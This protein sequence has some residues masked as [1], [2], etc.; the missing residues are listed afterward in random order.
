MSYCV[1]C[2]VELAPSEEKCPLCKTPVL[3][4]NQAW[5]EPG[6]R[7]Y[8]ERLEVVPPH[9]DRQYGA[10]L[11]SLFLMIPMLAVLI[12]DMVINL[13]MTWVHVCIGRGRVRLLLGAA[14][15][16][17]D[18][19]RPYFYI[20]VDIA[21]AALYLLL[22]AFLT[23]GD[24][25][26]ALALPLTLIWG[27]AAML[28]VYIGRRASMAPLD[29]ASLVVLVGAAALAGLEVV[30]D[31]WVL[32]SVRLEW[33]LYALA[34][35]AASARCSGSL[36]ESQAQGEHHE[37]T[38]PVTKSQGVESSPGAFR[39]E[40]GSLPAIGG[41]IKCSPGIPQSLCK[42]VVYYCRNKSDRK[43]L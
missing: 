19:E 36:N 1:H 35:L 13:R 28:S 14:P 8:P 31:L 4:P 29:K 41:V 32:K 22:I 37:E 5:R 9:I 33:S 26:L 42:N 21:S 3:D 40:R 15:M 20:A 34:P 12:C 11:A 23:G 18:I 16:S 7:P 6:E 25:Y 27:G 39:R 30:I 24:W 43:N 10:Q 2:G 38:V 17:L